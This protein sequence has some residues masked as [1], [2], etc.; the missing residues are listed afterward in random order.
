MS[1]FTET[2][3]SLTL[4]YFLSIFVFNALALSLFLAIF[5]QNYLK[6]SA[7]GDKY[8]VILSFDQLLIVYDT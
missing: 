1:Q 6:A 2:Y 3:G 8:K 7:Y 5:Y 4:L